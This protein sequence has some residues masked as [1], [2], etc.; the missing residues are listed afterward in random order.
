[1]L[2]IG[3]RFLLFCL[4]VVVL[5]EKGKEFKEIF[6]GDFK[7]KWKVVFFWFKDFIFVCFIE[8]VE[9][10]CKNCDF[11]DCDMQVLG[12]S[13]DLEYVYFV[14]CKDYFDLCNLF[15]FMLFDIKCELLNGFG[16]FDWYVGVL[17]CVMFV[18][19]F[20]GVICFVLVND[21]NVG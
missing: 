20:E 2:I 14:W 10:G 21:F 9:F 4:Q 1:M 16:I 3:D 11:G 18:I 6:D 8:I 7:G 19:D 15:F 12:V 17:L 13:F 5:L